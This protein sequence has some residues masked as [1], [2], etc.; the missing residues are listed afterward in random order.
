MLECEYVYASLEALDQMS[1]AAAHSVL[2]FGVPTG[3]GGTT[4][5][6]VSNSGLSSGNM[7]LL[8][9]AVVTVV[10]IVASCWYA[11]RRWLNSCS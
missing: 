11:R 9:G 10:A 5:F 7:A 1:D 4:S 3:V 8:T 2:T 6:M